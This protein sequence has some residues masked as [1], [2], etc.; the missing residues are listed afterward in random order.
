MIA[1]NLLMVIIM[2]F[3]AEANVKFEITN[4]EP[5][6]IWVGVQGNPGHPHLHGGGFVLNKGQTVGIAASS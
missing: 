2:A 6:A 1:L 5:G 4:R 3:C